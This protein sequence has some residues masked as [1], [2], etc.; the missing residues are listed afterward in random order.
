MKYSKKFVE[1]YDPLAFKMI[2]PKT[3]LEHMYLDAFH[4]VSRRNE[5]L[6][7]K[8]LGFVKKVKIVPDDECE[9]IKRFKKTY[10]IDEVPEL[11]LT[12]CN[13]PFCRCYF[14][15]IISKDH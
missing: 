5:I 7:L 15:A 8:K 4:R 12:G 10:N 11:P 14:E 6:R 1:C 3:T 13:A 9:K 2:E